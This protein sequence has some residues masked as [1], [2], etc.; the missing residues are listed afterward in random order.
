MKVKLVFFLCCCLLLPFSVRAKE[1]SFGVVPQFE[2]QKLYAIWKPVLKV[3]EQ[4]TGYKFKMQGTESI[5]EFEK[6]FARGR[7]DF[8]YM[9]PWHSLTAFEQQGYQPLVRSGIRQL[10]GILVVR[11]GSAIDNIQQLEGQSV[12]FPAPNALAASLLMRAEL[13]NLHHVTVHPVYVGTHSSS[14][15]NV[16][17]KETVAAGG[18]LRTLKNQSDMIKNLLRIIY[19]TQ[20]IPPHPISAHPRVPQTV[21]HQVQMAFLAMKEEPEHQKLLAKIPMREPVIATIKDYQILKRLGLEK[22][23]VK[24]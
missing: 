7:Y 8:A 19:K 17:L 12:A 14:Y 24:N 11:K 21:V 20:K 2:A 4:K 15:L 1:F 9:N 13:A 10:Q 3:L 5:P 22:F 16:A 23:Y 18:V 6:Q